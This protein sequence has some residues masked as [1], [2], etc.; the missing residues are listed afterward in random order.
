MAG[1]RYRPGEFAVIEGTDGAGKGTQVA[2]LLEHCALIGQEC[3]TMDFPRY[4][5]EPWGPIIKRYLNGEFGGLTETSPFLAALPYMLDRVRASAEIE[6]A[7]MRGKLFIANRFSPSNHAFQTAK[8]PREEWDDFIGWL[9]WTE[10]KIH[11]VPEPDIVV[12]MKVTPD[13][14]HANVG[15]RAAGRDI[16]EDNLGY[17]NRVAKVYMHL[18]EADPKWRI[19]D[20]MDGD[21][22]KSPEEIN[23]ILID[24][25]INEGILNG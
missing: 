5:V 12:L 21:K 1:K 8:L 17:Q 24:L 19:I 3:A 4:S 18:A 23:E 15:T 22:M 11:E 20:C 14:S 7:L 2:A 16:H 13:V 6:E 10:H 9:K 25:L